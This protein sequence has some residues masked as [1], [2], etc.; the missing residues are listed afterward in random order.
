MS[1]SNKPDPRGFKPGANMPHGD[2][3]P[4]TQGMSESGNHAT[5]DAGNDTPPGNLQ[6]QQRDSG[7]ARSEH[8]LRQD[9]QNRGDQ[10]NQQSASAAATAATHRDKNAGARG[11]SSTDNNQDKR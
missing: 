9:N 7:P 8:A 3:D 4:K 6:Q 2:Y 10:R 11:D 1:A 5:G